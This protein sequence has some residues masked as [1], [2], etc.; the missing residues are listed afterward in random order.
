MNKSCARLTDDDLLAIRENISG[1]TK[2]IRSGDK[3]ELAALFT[4]NGNYLPSNHVMLTG[5]EAIQAYQETYPPLP[6]FNL[7]IDEIDG[8]VD[9]A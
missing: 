9:L 2:T 1:F 6:N 7:T 5:R 4:E 3:K 8:C